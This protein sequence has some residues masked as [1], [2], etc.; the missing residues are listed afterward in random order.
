MRLIVVSKRSIPEHLASLIQECLKSDHQPP[1]SDQSLVELARGDR[2]LIDSDSGA[3]II[4]S[5]EFELAVAPSRRSLGFGSELVERV[6]RVHPNLQSTWSHGDHP[7]ARVLA[8]RFGFAPVRTLLK[9]GTDLEDPS[10]QGAPARAPKAPHPNDN[11][12]IRAFIP[13]TDNQEW[14]K[15]NAEAFA[16]HPEQGQITNQDLLDR[17]AEPWFDSN[18]FLL[19][20]E[21]N[22]LIAFNWL[23]IDG[24]AGEIYAIGVDPALQGRG[25]GA[26]LMQAGVERLSDRGIRY[27]ELYVEADNLAAIALYNSLGFVEIARDVQYRKI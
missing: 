9:L 24:D 11:F 21:G 23:K 5:S 25:V 15:L 17:I 27:A 26:R 10:L 1:F 22:R 4:A 8:K 13:G 16:S 3:A 18:D 2:S 19:M 20:F 7:A 14:L 12:T 6:L